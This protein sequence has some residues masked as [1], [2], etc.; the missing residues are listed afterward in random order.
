MLPQMITL[1]ILKKIIISL[2]NI[3]R[4]L[5]MRKCT[6]IINTLKKFLP[7]PLDKVTKEYVNT[8]KESNL[9]GLPS[10]LSNQKIIGSNCMGN[11]HMK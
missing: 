4:E 7:H 3:R 5:K 1:N 10:T 8:V 9:P 6:F 11:T 2:Y